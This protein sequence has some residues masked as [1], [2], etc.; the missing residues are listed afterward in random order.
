MRARY[1]AY[2]ICSTP[3]SGSTLLCKLLEATGVAGAADSHFHEPSIKAWAEDYGLELCDFA[4]ELDALTAIVSAA[5]R[6]GSS[7][8]GMFGLR[9]QRGSFAYFIEQL[10][11]MFPAGKTEAERIESAFG[12]TCYVHLTRENKLDQAISRVM[13]EQTGLWHR[14]ADGRELERLSAPREPQYNAAEIERHLRELQAYDAQWAQWLAQENLQPVA[15]TYEALAADP[16]AEV[17]RL[18]NALGLDGSLAEELTPP[19]AKLADSTSQ[20]WAER[21]ERKR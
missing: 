2:V 10:S 13:A 5:K 8:N 20:V 4:T 14:A 16:V 19:T 9:M 15:I 1:D 6:R 11:R 3:R 21:F 18:L 17:S 7:A 12:K